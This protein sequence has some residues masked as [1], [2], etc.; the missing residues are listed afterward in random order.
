MAEA[1]AKIDEAVA[2]GKLDA[3]RAEAIKAELPAKA[4]RFVNTEHPGRAALDRL[5]DR[6]DGRE[7][8]RGRLGERRH[9]G[10]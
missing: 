9:A 10:A 1:S 2:A 3:E 7:R 4:E 8:F 6:A 5:R